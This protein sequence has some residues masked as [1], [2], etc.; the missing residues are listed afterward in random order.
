MPVDTPPHNH[1]TNPFPKYDPTMDYLPTWLD[2][3]EDHLDVHIT[4]TPKKRQHCLFLLG[5]LSEVVRPNIS[6]LDTWT[7]VRKQVIDTLEGAAQPQT[8]HH[9][10]CH[11]RYDGDWLDFHRQAE[12]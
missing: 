10:L 9:Q 4:E 1:P 2:L 5:N 8:A 11:L 12:R 3:L 7:E 6:D